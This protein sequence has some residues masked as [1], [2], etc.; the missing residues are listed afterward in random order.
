[1][2]LLLVLSKCAKF[3]LK[4]RISN[5]KVDIISKNKESLD[6][7]GEI[8]TG[9]PN[10]DKTKSLRTRP[11]HSVLQT[12]F[13]TKD[14]T[15]LLKS[16]PSTQNLVP[17]GAFNLTT[18]P[19]CP[20][21]KKSMY[22]SI[23]EAESSFK[24]SHYGSTSNISDYSL[25][26]VRLSGGSYILNT[27]KDSL[28]NS[29]TLS[30]NSTCDCLSLNTLPKP[31]VSKKDSYV[32][33]SSLKYSSSLY[34]DHLSTE[35]S[36]RFFSLPTFG[37]SGGSYT[38]NSDKEQ[39]ALFNDL[40]SL[41]PCVSTSENYNSSMNALCF[42]STHVF[43]IDERSSYQYNP[44]WKYN[45]LKKIKLQDNEDVCSL[46][47]SS[48]PI[49]FQ[50]EHLNNTA[51]IPHLPRKWCISQNKSTVKDVSN[52]IET[53]QKNDLIGY[54]FKL[55]KST[56][57]LAEKYRVLDSKIKTSLMNKRGTNDNDKYLELCKISIEELLQA[58]DSALDS[59]KKI[60]S[61]NKNSQNSETG[62]SSSFCAT[63]EKMFF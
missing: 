58:L 4:K 25:P 8:E 38:L 33:D 14:D 55:I 47:K 32:T 43:G 26:V 54:F 59:I 5:H 9:N 12:E 18:L 45:S 29:L 46:N 50:R 35:S 39:L 7:M 28:K 27:V 34:N 40:P 23:N 3:E 13:I 10:K 2:I 51:L 20:Q 31:E 17:I 60:R 42:P 63:G 6:C 36:T 57:N 1:M 24:G 16:I 56:E 48:K 52:R 22:V 11:T 41:K 30:G 15:S 44:K 37:F 61:I 19:S 53:H 49:N 62:S 21:V